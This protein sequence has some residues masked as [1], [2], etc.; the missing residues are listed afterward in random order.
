MIIYTSID[1][2]T[3]I[4]VRLEDETLWLTQ[5]QMCE[6][7]QTSKSNVSEHI[8]HIF[9]EGELDEESV[10]RKF[11]TTAS[12][13][14][15]YNTTFYNLDM[16][17]ALGYRIKSVIA[18]R[19]RQWVTQ[20]LKEYMIKGFT[21][22]KSPNI[23]ITAKREYLRRFRISD[24]PQFFRF[25]TFYL[26]FCAGFLIKEKRYVDKWYLFDCFADFFEYLHD[27]C[28]VRTSEDA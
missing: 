9:E 6:L 15:S 24:Q 8:K 14:K 25:V 13:G 17:I 28:L 18:T 16:I 27:F 5:A 21:L 7:Y 20:Q 26:Y 11:R 2:Q 10:V 19:F 22:T 23:R 1:G 3:K 12:D 4:D